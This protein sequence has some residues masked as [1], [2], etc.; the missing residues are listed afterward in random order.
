MSLSLG[1]YAKA[2]SVIGQGV[3]HVVWYCL[4]HQLGHRIVR[5]DQALRG[6][7]TKMHQVVGRQVQKVFTAVNR[8][9]TI[10]KLIRN[11]KTKLKGT[12]L[13]FVLV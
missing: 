6:L 5:R 3:L 11:D 8:H 4:H 10:Q 9:N 13:F 12:E 7:R 2:P 1:I